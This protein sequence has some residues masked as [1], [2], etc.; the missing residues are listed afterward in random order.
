M[1]PPGLV[2]FRVVEAESDL[3]ISAERNLETEASALL[4]HERSELVRYIA[5]HPDFATSL[6]PLPIAADA[7]EL[8]RSMTQ[9]A[10]LADVGPMA[11]VAGALAERVGRGLL[12]MS[13][14]ILIENGGDI[15]LISHQPRRIAVYA[16]QSPLS[17]RIAITVPPAPAGLGICTSAGTIGHSLSF[18]RADAAMIISENTALAD[19]VATGMG[20]LVRSDADVQAALEVARS[21]EGV[22][23]ALIIIG[24]TLAGWGQIK[25]EPL[26]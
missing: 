17:L 9:A 16:G 12:Q 1:K 21:V 26:A 7:P 3:F 22:L 4:H 23:G 15:F 25:I 19:A 5:A 8:V 24:K 6:A 14:E 11:A 18:G 10:V 13:P 2:G 20:N